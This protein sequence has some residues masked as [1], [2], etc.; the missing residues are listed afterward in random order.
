MLKLVEECL[1]SRQSAER[2]PKAI[3]EDEDKEAWGCYWK[4]VNKWMCNEEA[5]KRQTTVE[6]ESDR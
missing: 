4:A 1:S 2:W 5:T 6:E 3:A